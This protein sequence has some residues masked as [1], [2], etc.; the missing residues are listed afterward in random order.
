M[1]GINLLPW[2]EQLRVQQKQQFVFAIAGC[3]LVTIL[4]LVSLHIL[5]EM[6]FKHQIRNN[7][8]LQ[9]AVSS[10]DQ[11]I[12]E[13]EDLKVQKNQFIERMKNIQHL[14][15]NRPQIVRLFRVCAKGS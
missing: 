14:Q 11:K 2:R 3:L 1:K 12:Q 5:V 15:I 7:Q 13:V 10:Y 6:H 9:Q 8:Y 4:M